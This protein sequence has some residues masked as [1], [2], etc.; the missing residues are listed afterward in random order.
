MLTSTST[1]AKMGDQGSEA[2]TRLMDPEISIV[3]DV[4][5]DLEYYSRLVK[6]GRFGKA[7]IFFR[8]VLH[9]G[10]NHF[11]VLAE[12]CNALIDQGDFVNAELMLSHS[13]NCQSI[14]ARHSEPFE[15]DQLQLLRLLLAYVSIYNGRG[16]QQEEAKALIQARWSRTLLDTLDP[17]KI[18]D[19][20]VRDLGISHRLIEYADAPAATDPSHLLAHTCCRT[21]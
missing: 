14:S 3:Q 10:L 17:N 21:D 9:R 18:T 7:T 1:E 8:E 15:P 6:L 13:I 11:A 2:D 19:V 12:H 4:E 5:E 20:Q 16:Q